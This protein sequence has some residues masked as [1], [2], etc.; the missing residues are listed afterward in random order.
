MQS[1]WKSSSSGFAGGGGGYAAGGPSLIQQQ[2]AAQ[3]QREEEEV[4]GPK[5]EYQFERS[6]KFN[7]QR[8]AFQRPMQVNG[9]GILFIFLIIHLYQFKYLICY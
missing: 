2:I 5:E 7:Q 3:Q 4:E 1:E 9:Q 6:S 8:Q